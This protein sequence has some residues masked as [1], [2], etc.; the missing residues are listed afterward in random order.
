MTQV[1]I[2]DSAKIKNETYSIP[3]LFLVCL[4]Q[5]EAT[6]LSTNLYVG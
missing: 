4:L 3:L 6:N 1:R 5:N 2:Q